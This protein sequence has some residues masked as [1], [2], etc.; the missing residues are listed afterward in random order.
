MKMPATKKERMLMFALIGV[1]GVVVLGGGI[2]WG[3]V[4]LLDGRRAMQSSLVE[5]GEKLKKA[6]RELE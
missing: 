6:K 3:V 2:M 4:P 1:V 5:I